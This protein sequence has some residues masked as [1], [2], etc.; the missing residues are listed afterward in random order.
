MQGLDVDYRADL[1]SLGVVAYLMLTGQAP[2]EAD[3]VVSL[4]HKHVYEAPPSARSLRPELP[5][6]VDAAL[7]HMLAKQPGERYP[8]AAAFVAALHEQR[9][10]EVT[11]YRPAQH[12]PVAS[13]HVQVKQPATPMSHHASTTKPRTGPAHRG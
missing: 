6:N 2:F 4:L 13:R 3:S 8:S 5:E 12:E 10:P 1:Y 7:N 11:V 9:P